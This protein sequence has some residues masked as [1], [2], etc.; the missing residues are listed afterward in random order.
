MKSKDDNVQAF[1]CECGKQLPIPNT[2]DGIIQLWKKPIKNCTIERPGNLKSIKIIDFN[3]YSNKGL[4]ISILSKSNY[5]VLSDYFYTGTSSIK[6]ILYDNKRNECECLFA[7]EYIHNKI[8]ELHGIE[9]FKR[10]YYKMKRLCNYDIDG[11]NNNILAAIY[12]IYELLSKSY[13]DQIYPVKV[14]YGILEK[15]YVYND[16]ISFSRNIFKHN[17]DSF[18]KVNNIQNY[19]YKRLLEERFKQL[20]NC[21][22]SNNKDDFPISGWRIKYKKGFPIFIIVEDIKGNILLYD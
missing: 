1:Q 20:K 9:E 3:N 19:I 21:F 14:E 8:I 6:P 13:I 7:A 18:Y 4:S 16:F 10:H 12:L 2:A 15:D 17:N 5:K 22:L 11:Y